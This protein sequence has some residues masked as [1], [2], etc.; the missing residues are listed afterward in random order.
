MDN[1]DLKDRIGDIGLELYDVIDRL[2]SLIEDYPEYAADLK[3][4]ADKID[5]IKFNLIF[6]GD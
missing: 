1:T 2:E 6:V 5:D 4:A 3:S